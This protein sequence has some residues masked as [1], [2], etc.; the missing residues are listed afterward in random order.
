MPEP[1]QQIEAD[2]QRAAL[3]PVF[4][5]AGAT[6]LDLVSIPVWVHDR[7]RESNVYA[8]AAGLRFWGCDSIAELA[9]RSH[10]D[11][12]QT[13][14]ARLDGLFARIERGER[15]VDRWTF[16]PLG[17]P[18]TV[19]GTISGVRFDDGRLGLLF[20]AAPSAVDPFDRR[21]AEALRYASVLATLYDDDG[22]VL[23]RNP[24]AVR[25]Y[26][27][28]DHRFV[29]RFSSL[30]E[31]VAT[32]KRLRAGM[33]VNAIVGVN[34]A[35]GPRWHGLDARAVT[36][37][38]TGKPCVLVNERDVTALKS[39][40]ASVA[41][42][43]RRLSE[44]QQIARLGDWRLDA[45]TGETRLSTQ[46]AAMFGF[47]RTTITAEQLRTL[48]NDGDGR[49]SAALDRVTAHGGG[50]EAV[51]RL[52][53]ASGRHRH[54][55]TR[56][57]ARRDEAGRIAEIV[58]V[59]RDITEE[60]RSRER[61]DYLA[62]HD[63]V[64]RLANRVRFGEALIEAMLRGRERGGSIAVMDLDGFKE[65][66]DRYGHD[67]GDA[68]LVEIGRRLSAA[69]RPGEIVARLGGDEF[70]LIFGP[71]SAEAVRQRLDAVL[72]R[73]M[74]P[75]SI[76]GALVSV[77][78]IVGLASW[79]QHGDG[80]E[81]LQ[82]NADL[83]LYSAKLQGGGKAI[84]YA[85]EMRA[86]RDARRWVA[87]EL[88]DALLN[89][90][91]EV[92]YQPI[93]ALS[94]GRLAGF[95]ALVRWRHALRGLVQPDDFVALAEDAGLGAPLGSHVLREALE[96]L[97]R[98]L[99]AGL[100]PGR[101][102][103]NL[104]AGHITEGRVSDEVVD[105]LARLAIPTQRLEL[106]VTESV[107]LRPRAGGV[108]G[109]IGALHALGV[110]I[111]LDDFG[112]GQASLTHLNRLPVDRV[113]I[114]RSFVAEIARD[115]R[116]AAIVRAITALAREL[117]MSVVAEGVETAEQAA[118]LQAAGC[119]F[120]QGFLFGRPMPGEVAA[121]WMRERIHIT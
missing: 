28:D 30:V 95:E 81:T 29:D 7:E 118:L 117:G 26:P 4:S 32:W 85:P 17:Q 20:E 110:S 63:S 19:D 57:A 83:A 78:A 73:G 92:H 27:A 5:F 10:A 91:I 93:V 38:V 33:P 98:W 66:N 46:L 65:I 56:F 21:A 22:R 25:A 120:A 97:R 108:V 15:L 16:Y 44:A 52:E 105:T 48:L 72:E 13:S 36:D 54:V 76:D 67:A 109:T 14:R 88:P 1:A 35:E 80:P 42:R 102:A 75:V 89:G 107:T 104:G 45:A 9:T 86:A 3:L 11:M 49:F 47:G 51:S 24:A 61:I 62:M 112:T 113:K 12:S 50:A 53:L 40:E 43:E 69:A 115:G 55:W 106:E 58:G 101:L 18:V 99:D 2:Q 68:V 23:F 94:D 121:A 6:A 74:A 103:V 64:T 41:E 116:E 111:V 8:N 39:A 59:A 90:A 82:Q 71:D 84:V 77:G 119:E 114:D 96:Q 70:G 34:T 100:E 37:P 60:V 31:A 79:P 87:V